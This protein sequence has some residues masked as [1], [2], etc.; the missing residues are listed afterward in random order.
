MSE[1]VVGFSVGRRC[2]ESSGRRESEGGP[3]SRPRHRRIGK[4]SDAETPRHAPLDCGLDD[5][6]REEGQRDC[7]P[8][9]AFGPALAD[10][11]GFD[12][13]TPIR[14]QLVK[15]AMGVAQTLDDADAGLLSH[16]T[17]RCGL[18]TLALKDLSAPGRRRRRPANGQSS[19]PALASDGVRQLDGDRGSADRDPLDRGAEIGGMVAIVGVGV[20]AAADRVRDPLLDFGRGNSRD[21]TGIG[22]AALEQ[23]LGDIVAP[24]LAA[25]RRM[26]GAHRVA[27]IVEQLARQK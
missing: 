18:R 5:G 23:R 10:G 8:D 1:M 9:R 24:A 17:D 19:I 15:P 6:G 22:F 26:A 21:R 13:L 2:S 20:E 25:L 3:L 27:A 7:H 11:D 14:H 12:A 4:P 16:R